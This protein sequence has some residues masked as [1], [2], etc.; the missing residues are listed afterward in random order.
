M[1]L[2]QYSAQLKS[3]ELNFVVDSLR[4]IYESDAECVIYDD[5]DD[6]SGVDQNN[7]ICQRINATLARYDRM[8]RV[9]DSFPLPLLD[10]SEE[11]VRIVISQAEGGLITHLN[12]SIGEYNEIRT[13]VMEAVVKAEYDLTEALNDGK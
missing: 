4:S 11:I 1:R 2:A 8:G 13:R 10:V 7:S 6:S 12:D 3:S 5:N 9:A